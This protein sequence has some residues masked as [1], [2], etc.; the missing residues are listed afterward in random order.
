MSETERQKKIFQLKLKERQL[1]KEGRVDEA[2]A[3][4]GGLQIV[5]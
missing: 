1:R 4:L 5:S 3:L 2:N